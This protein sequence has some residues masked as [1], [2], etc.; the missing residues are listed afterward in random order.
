M[1]SMRIKRWMTFMTILFLGLFVFVGSSLAGV[2]KNVT[3]RAIVITLASGQRATVAAQRTVTVSQ[4]DMT[5]AN[6]VRLIR[7]GSLVVVQPSAPA[8]P[9]N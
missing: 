3:S 2:L 7:S 8:R 4:Q 9:R 5:Q 1:L 6:I